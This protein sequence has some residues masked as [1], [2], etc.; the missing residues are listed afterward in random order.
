MKE[1]LGGSL[2]KAFENLKIHATKTYEGNTWLD[3]K[4]QVWEVL[5]EDFD[6]LLNISDDFWYNTFDYSW[7]RHSEGSVY[8]FPYIDYIINEQHLKAWDGHARED[9]EYEKEIFDGEEEWDDWFQNREYDSLLT[10][11]DEEIG[12]T[13]ERS[14]CALASDLAKGN[15]ISMGELFNKYQGNKK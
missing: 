4:T 15:G 7:W 11:L 8:G 3:N 6:K 13:A 5:D 1:I 14:V 12:A 10:Y 2:D 9:Y